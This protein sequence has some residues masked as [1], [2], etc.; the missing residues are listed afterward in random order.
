[1]LGC[2]LAPILVFKL[3]R[4][5]RGDSAGLRLE[6]M[7][8]TNPSTFNNIFSA[9]CH[10]LCCIPG[11]CGVVLALAV[12]VPTVTAQVAK[13]PVVRPEKDQKA[14][15]NPNAPAKTLR[16]DVPDP[17]HYRIKGRVDSEGS[18]NLIK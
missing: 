15:K 6:T 13:P 8:N 17:D 10:A 2:S 16:A 1:M 11:T 5:N 14:V 9:L 4:R 3:S 12:L 18:E 7:P